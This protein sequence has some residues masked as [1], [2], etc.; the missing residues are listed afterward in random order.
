MKRLRAIIA[1][2]LFAFLLGGATAQTAPFSSFLPLVTNGASPSTVKILE[3]DY[4]LVSG[5]VSP[6]GCEY[7]AVMDRGGGNF[8]HVG[9][10]RG[11]TFVEVTPPDQPPAPAF[12]PDGAKH[13]GMAL[14]I[15]NGNLILLYTS[16]PDGATTGGFDLYKETMPLP[17]CL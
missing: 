17:S 14:Y 6:A 3:G 7:I 4:T 11:E 2:S 16:R 15:A 8:I 10:L 12:V 9:Y 5:V 13:A 1:A